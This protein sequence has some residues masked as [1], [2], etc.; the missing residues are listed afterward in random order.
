MVKTHVNDNG[1]FRTIKEIYVN[2]SGTWRNIDEAYENDNGTWRRVHKRRPDLISSAGTISFTESTFTYDNGP[3]GGAPVNIANNGGVSDYRN[4]NNDGRDDYGPFTHMFTSFIKIADEPMPA[5]ETVRVT[6][7]SMSGDMH[8]LPWNDSNFYTQNNT[9]VL[10][11][12]NTAPIG[13][14]TGT[15]F[16]VGDSVSL[17]Q[18]RDDNAWASSVTVPSG[19]HTFVGGSS[20]ANT[21]FNY[22]GAANSGTIDISSF[23]PC[24]NF[25]VSSSGQSPT[26]YVSTIRTFIEDTAN[27]TQAGV[28]VIIV[29]KSRSFP[30]S[31]S[32]DISVEYV[33]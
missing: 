22:D 8:I 6:I 32:Y 2:D 18:R 30:F 19:G 20:N 28:P 33:D 7:N 9:N 21:G 24:T 31:G 25:G 5:G 11:T 17:A 15:A 3:F 29:R 26:N 16:D 1:T 10:S 23:F 4:D 14:V 27:Q 13:D 12:T